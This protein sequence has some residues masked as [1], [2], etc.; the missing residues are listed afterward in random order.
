L[1]AHAGFLD[2]LR[3]AAPEIVIPHAVAEE[4][5]RRGPADPTAQAIRNSPWLRENEPSL[6]PPRMQAG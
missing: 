1:L 5:R 2:F 3:Y 6:P 4:I